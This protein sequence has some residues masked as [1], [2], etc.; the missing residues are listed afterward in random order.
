MRIFLL[1]L[2]M[3]WYMIPFLYLTI[4]PIFY[5]MQGDFQKQVKEINN[6][7]KMLWYGF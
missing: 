7:S 3:G 2:L 5:L 6:V 4:L 1:R